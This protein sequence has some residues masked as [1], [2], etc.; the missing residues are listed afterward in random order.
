MIL[1][2]LFTTLLL[3]TFVMQVIP[4]DDENCRWIYRCCKKVGETCEMLCEPEI[5]CDEPET[6]T[7]TFVPVISNAA[8]FHVDCKA[9]YKHDHGKCRRL[10]K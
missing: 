3:L 5:I 4:A 9:G 10:L 8:V 7:E 1:A 6:T 2:H